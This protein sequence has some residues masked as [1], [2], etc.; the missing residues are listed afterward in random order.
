[1]LFCAVSFYKYFNRNL[2]FPF[3]VSALFI[4]TKNILV[5][6]CATILDSNITFLCLISST[7]K[8]FLL[9]YWHAPPC[10]AEALRNYRSL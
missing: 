9:D 5:L 10:F 6:N 2:N 7:Q 3:N 1:M 4:A 8:E